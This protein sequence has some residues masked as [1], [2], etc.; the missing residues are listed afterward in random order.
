MIWYTVADVV[1]VLLLQYFWVSYSEIE[2]I[3]YC[4][5]EQLLARARLPK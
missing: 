3:T 2:T 5:F 4:Q 1:G